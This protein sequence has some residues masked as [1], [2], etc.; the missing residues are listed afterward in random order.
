MLKQCGMLV[1]VALQ[2]SLVVARPQGQD[3]NQQYGSWGSFSGLGG[4]L[5][6]GG[7]GT[8]GSNVGVGVYSGHGGPGGSGGGQHGVNLFGSESASFNG[9]GALNLGVY[10]GGYRNALGTFGVPGFGG[11]QGYGGQ[12]GFPALHGGFAG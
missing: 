11:P 10:R 1:V 9:Q 12:F 6:L 4:S 7:S 8:L 3:N 2:L 5:N